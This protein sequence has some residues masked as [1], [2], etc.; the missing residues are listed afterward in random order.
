MKVPEGADKTIVKYNCI[1][2]IMPILDSGT[3]YSL[4]EKLPAVSPAAIQLV[5]LI[6]NPRTT[7]DQ[8]VQLVSTDE[9]LLA[10]C[11]KQANS[12]AMGFN[13]EY[14]SIPSIIDVLGFSYI[15][16]V[17]MFVAAKSI[18]NDPTVWFESVFLGVAAQYLARKANLS[19]VDADK[20]Y[21]A[22]LFLN[23]GSYF[24]KQFYPAIYANVQSIKSFPLRMK[25]EFEEFGI[26]FP[27]VSA[28]I[29]G[30][31]D[32]PDS[33]IEIIRTQALAY[34]EG[35]TKENACIEVARLMLNLQ[36]ADADTIRARLD[37]NEVRQLVAGKGIPVQD[38]DEKS[39]EN[40]K[41]DTRDYAMSS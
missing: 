22:A 21:M 18:I 27:E 8:I 25:Q 12:A 23:F 11:F 14:T 37:I 24:F 9:T 41:V 28:M 29:L 36:S 34:K 20:V 10:Q 6:D 31:Y 4:A 13:R 19:A 35:A 16:K 1:E 26:T 38:I 5:S 2:Q 40:I 32:V 33:V 15:R 30:T 7:R 3:I 17:G 39:I